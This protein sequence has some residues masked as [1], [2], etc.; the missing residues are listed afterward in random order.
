MTDTR[1]YIDEQFDKFFEFDTH[2][3]STVTST[4]CKLFA[5]HLIADLLA[6]IGRK[7][8]ALKFYADGAHIRHLSNG[9][10]VFEYGDTAQEAL[11]ITADGVELVEVG[12]TMAL[13]DGT[14]SDS[15]FDV[16]STE[17]FETQTQ[18]KLYTIK[19]KGN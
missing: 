1:K 5:E 2:D 16:T 17:V 18:I 10:C 4:S 12:D 3:K 6:V 9:E 8:A 14:L 15:M 19:Q 11:A 7:D 13:P